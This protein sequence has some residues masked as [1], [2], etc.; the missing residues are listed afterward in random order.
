MSIAI[1]GEASGQKEARKKAPSAEGRMLYV[2]G[3]K[4]LT[5]T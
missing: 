2:S 4:S 3:A 5:D 1:T